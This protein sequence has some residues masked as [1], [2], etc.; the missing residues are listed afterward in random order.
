MSD[1]GQLWSETVEG[2]EIL[3]GA[4]A[5]F[6]DLVPRQLCQ[7]T[8]WWTYNEPVGR[9]FGSDWRSCS[10]ADHFHIW[11]LKYRN[12]S[13]SSALVPFLWS[14]QDCNQWIWA[15]ESWFGCNDSWAGILADSQL[16]FHFFS[17]DSSF[18]RAKKFNLCSCIQWTHT[19]K[20][21]TQFNLKT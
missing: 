18:L 5:S 10:K 15:V 11:K 3:L 19:R 14:A 8:L 4:L 12:T 7:A 1:L 16:C 17:L 2:P 9:W 6:G 20:Q 21:S 13:I